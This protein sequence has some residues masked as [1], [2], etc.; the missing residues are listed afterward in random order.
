[1]SKGLLSACARHPAE[2]LCFQP[3]WRPDVCRMSRTAAASSQTHLPINGHAGLADSLLAT[4]HTV[5]QQ[6]AHSPRLAIA[7]LRT[8]DM[9][10]AET[11]IGHRDHACLGA[12]WLPGSA[13]RPLQQLGWQVP[14]R[15]LAQNVMWCVGAAAFMGLQGC[16]SK[17]MR[18]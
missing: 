17:T 6:H 18:C 5:W 1:M 9:L 8:A 14:P 11:E 16:V 2:L 13:Q 12:H 10:L 7:L 3:G 4:L 15:L